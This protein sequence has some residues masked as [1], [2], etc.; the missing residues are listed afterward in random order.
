MLSAA[1]GVQITFILEWITF[2]SEAAPNSLLPPVQEGNILTSCVIFGKW[3]NLSET[4]SSHLLNGEG[5]S[6][7]F[8]RHITSSKPHSCPTRLTLLSDQF[9]RWETEAPVFRCLK[10]TQLVCVEARIVF[11][12]LLSGV[13][14][15][16]NPMDCSP[17]GF[18]VYRFSHTRILECVAISFPTQG[19]NLCLLLWQADSL[20]LDHQGSPKPE[21]LTTNVYNQLQLPQVGYV[22]I[23]LRSQNTTPPIWAL[24]RC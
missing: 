10:T 20:P 1:F 18:S 14:L 22:D 15:F 21:Y 23:Q 2:I 16:C 24:D 19:L 12:Y 11:F 5:K 3:L 7:R 17:P 6:A 9:Y 13:W 4:Y 8:L